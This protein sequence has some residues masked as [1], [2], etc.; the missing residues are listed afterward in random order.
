MTSSEK[1][2]TA[3]SEDNL[4]DLDSAANQSKSD[5]DGEKWAKH[6]RTVKNGKGQTNA[7]YFGIDE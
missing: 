6:V 7:E 3:N 4:Y 1:V 2:E 5:H